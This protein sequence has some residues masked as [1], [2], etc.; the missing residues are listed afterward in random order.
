LCCLLGE[1]GRQTQHLEQ[2]AED[3]NVDLFWRL[4]VLELLEFVEWPLGEQRDLTGVDLIAGDRQDDVAGIDQPAENGS[5]QIGLEAKLDR[6]EILNVGVAADQLAAVQH[7]TMSLGFQPG[8]HIQGITRPSG[9]DAIAI[10]HLQSVED[11][12]G[13]LRAGPTCKRAKSISD[14][15][16][17]V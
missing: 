2:R 11:H 17:P 9:V 6:R 3:G 8:Q 14:E 13:V 10:E 7:L 5:Q 12:D 4:D 1:A 15:L 16:L